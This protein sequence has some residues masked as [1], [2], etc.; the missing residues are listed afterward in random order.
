MRKLLVVVMLM[1]AM[2]TMALASVNSTK[3]MTPANQTNSSTSHY[4]FVFNATSNNDAYLSC[5]LY[6][7]LFSGGPSVQGGDNLTIANNTVGTIT[8]GGVPIGF[9]DDLWYWKVQ[10]NDTT[11]LLNSSERWFKVHSASASLTNITIIRY[12]EP[13]S[14]SYGNYSFCAASRDPLSATSWAG[15]GG[16]YAGISG[17]QNA[18]LVSGSTYCY[19]TLVPQGSYT[20]YWQTANGYGTVTTSPTLSFVAGTLAQQCV[21]TKGIIYAAFTLMSAAEAAALEVMVLREMVLEEALAV[22]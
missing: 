1:A 22:K 15:V 16:T 21:S 3:L 8:G 20:Y 11:N 9:S 5:Q 17:F 14:D 6:V 18:T 19:N 12:T 4:S 7:S 2:A 13:T 10:C